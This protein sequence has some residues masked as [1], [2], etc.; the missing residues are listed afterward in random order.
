MALLERVYATTGMLWNVL[1]VIG[2][3]ADGMPPAGR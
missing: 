1:T 2:V 3:L